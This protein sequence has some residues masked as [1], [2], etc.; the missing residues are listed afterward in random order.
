MSTSSAS[1]AGAP[2]SYEACK[3]NLRAFVASLPKT[4]VRFMYFQGRNLAAP[5]VNTALGAWTIRGTPCFVAP[6]DQPN[7]CY[8]YRRSTVKYMISLRAPG[9][10]DASRAELAD[11]GDHVS[12]GVI[13]ARPDRV[14]IKTHKARYDEMDA[15][16]SDRR[17]LGECNFRAPPPATAAAS[18][19]RFE[20][21]VR[22]RDDARC[23]LSVA[24]GSDALVR[25]IVY[26]LY[27]AAAGLLPDA[28]PS[29]HAPLAGV[30]EH[31]G[32]TFGSPEFARFLSATLLQPVA[33]LRPDLVSVQVFFD[34]LSE[35][36][37]GP[38]GALL[39]LY[40]FEEGERAAFCARAA[41]ALAAAYVAEHPAEATAYEATCLQQFLAAVAHPTTGLA[42]SVA[43]L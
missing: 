35:L 6:A 14:V 27:R 22:D 8:V 11:H 12:F 40:D 26:E 25:E 21:L 10:P 29:A 24:Y 36:A 16:R 41:A 39:I 20:A 5:V 33:A 42:A 38:P 7:Y 19:E 28:A 31:R 23:T 3:Q 17:T 43:P 2:L 9:A 4:G 30:P 15:H 32:A 13:Q 37:P 18:R 34:E 1:T